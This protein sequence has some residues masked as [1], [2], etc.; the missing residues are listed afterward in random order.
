[1]SG[2]L[3][4]ATFQAELNKVFSVRLGGERL[5]LELIT[6]TDLGAR[7]TAGVALPCYSLVFRSRGQGPAAPQATYRMENGALGGIDVFLVPIGPDASG[8]RYE[9]IFN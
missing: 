6:V 1:M 4:L 2:R 7:T 9:A 5:E 3:P 8:M